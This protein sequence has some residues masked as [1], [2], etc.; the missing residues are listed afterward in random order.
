[1]VESDVTLPLPLPVVPEAD[2]DAEAPAVATADALRLAPALADRAERAEDRTLA[3]M[4]EATFV[5]VI[6][7]SNVVST[8]IVSS[9]L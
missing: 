4:D 3:S 9:P 7:P 2:A 8:P 6:E 5:V 1:V